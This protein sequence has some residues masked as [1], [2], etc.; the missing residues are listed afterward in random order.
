MLH[1]HENVVLHNAADTM[2]APFLCRNDSAPKLLQPKNSCGILSA[3]SEKDLPE[4]V[5]INPHKHE[6][7]KGEQQL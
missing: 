6:K 5:S 7:S 1:L 2:I 4:K 3:S